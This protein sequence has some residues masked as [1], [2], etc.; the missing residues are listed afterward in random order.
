MKAYYFVCYK[1]GASMLPDTSVG[2]YRRIA[3]AGEKEIVDI[4]GCEEI[5]SSYYGVDLHKDQITWHC[6]DRT[7]NGVLARSTGK[8]ST[9]RILEDFIPMLRKEGCY[10]VVEASGST[11]FFHSLIESHCTKAL[12]VNPAGFREMYMTGKK[13]DRIDAKKLADRL[14]YHIEMKDSDDGFPE[15][16]IPDKEALKIRKLVTTYELLVKQITQ[17]KNQVKAIFRSKI[18]RVDVDVLDNGL[19]KALENT[20]LD[21]A[22]RIIVQSLKGLYDTL[23]REKQTIKEAILSVGVRRFRDE[24]GLLTSISGVSIIGSIVFMADIVTVERFDSAKRLTS[25]LASVGKVDASGNTTRN[26]GLNKRG[27]RTSYRFILQGLE[28]IVNGNE[29]F[30]RFKARHASKRSN[31]IRAAIVRK[32]FVTMYYMLKN[33]DLY[34]FLNKSIYIRKIREMNKIMETSE[35]VA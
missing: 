1:I 6:I 35:K 29:G 23:C 27:R 18:I 17:A 11:F 13:T 4:S 12:I 31:K 21:N 32:T 30:Q 7:S 24:V 3:M 26:G 33:H 5:D 34:R 8:V 9:D 2:H 19:E 22:D 25:Y 20:R 28:H 16:F 15:V 10:V 14:M